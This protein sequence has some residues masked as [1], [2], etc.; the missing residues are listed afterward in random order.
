ME[1][2][3]INNTVEVEL[4]DFG[5]KV[6]ADRWKKV[7]DWVSEM[8]DEPCLISPPRLKGRTFNAPLWEI[9]NLF[10]PYSRMGNFNQCFI[11]N[12]IKV[13]SND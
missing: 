11:D 13:I 6:V 5:M 12:K 2:N 3:N 9:M 7:S 1:L 8:Q 10:G 4:T